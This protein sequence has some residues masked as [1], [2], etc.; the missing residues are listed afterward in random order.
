[1][2]ETPFFFETSLHTFFLSLASPLQTLCAC[3]VSNLPFLRSVLPKHRVQRDSRTKLPSDSYFWINTPHCRMNRLN[4]WV[5]K[6]AGLYEPACP[7]HTESLWGVTFFGLLPNKTVL[8]YLNDWNALFFL[9]ETSL[10][11]FF[12][13]TC[14]ASTDALCLFS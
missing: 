14:F 4:E 11:T 8:Q 10:H 5:R 6:T 7:S 9:F 12:F 3:S 13:V 2:I 1:M